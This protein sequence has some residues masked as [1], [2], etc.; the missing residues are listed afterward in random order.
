[1]LAHTLSKYLNHPFN[2]M[3]N[4][5]PCHD[6]STF[7]PLLILLCKDCLLSLKQRIYYIVSEPYIFFSILHTPIL[8]TASSV[9]LHLRSRTS[10]RHALPL[11]PVGMHFPYFLSACTSLTSCQHALPLLPVGMHFPYFLSA[12]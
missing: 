8:Y 12:C 1:M 6:F 10:C 2:N 7:I 3:I 4:I 5:Q 11:L 9:I